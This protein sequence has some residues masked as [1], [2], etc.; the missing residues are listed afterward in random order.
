MKKMRATWMV[1]VLIAVLGS[2]CKHEPGSV[3]L[4]RGGLKLECDEAVYRAFENEASEFQSLY[5][6]SKLR[7]QQAEAREAISDFGADSVRVIVTAR[8][9]NKEERDALQGA[10]VAL[11][12][13]KVAM[14]AVAV[15]VNPSN[16]LKRARLSHLD[17]IF[18][19]EVTRWPAGGLIEA[20]AA[21]RNSSTNETFR[22]TVLKTREFGPT[23]E[24]MDSSSGRIERVARTP[25]AVAIV[26]VTWLKGMEGRVTV[27]EIGAP[28]Y[29]PDTTAAPGQ[30]YQ[31][32]PAYVFLGYYPISTPVYMY[33]RAVEQDISL[34]FISFVSSAPGQK[35]IQNNG[36][37]PVTM[38]VRLV[39]LTSQQ[40]K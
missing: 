8:E 37:V 16:P 36:L 30:Y 28:G 33:S 1:A 4:V 24:Y 20:L 14:S 18:G 11:D 19:G 21:G 27:L 25:G 15:I 26:P 9:L 38:P 13:Y 10:K 40:V 29:R 17:S 7:L 3:N 22:S 31:P 23:V 35:I 39:S 5:P 6:E 12:E 2:G 32:W 34:G